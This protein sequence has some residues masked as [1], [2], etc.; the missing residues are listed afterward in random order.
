[1]VLEGK[2]TD[3][4]NGKY[5]FYTVLFLQSAGGTFTAALEK[6]EELIGQWNTGPI[7]SSCQMADQIEA[8]MGLL[9]QRGSNSQSIIF[10]HLV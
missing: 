9:L 2:P 7:I 3:V 5:D 6:A 4:T 10:R 1:M 8:Q